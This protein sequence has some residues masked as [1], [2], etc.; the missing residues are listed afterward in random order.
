[1]KHI[2][3]LLG[4]GAGAGRAF[5]FIGS[6]DREFYTGFNGFF[7]VDGAGRGICFYC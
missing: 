2:F 4:D 7:L 6:W 3:I 1:M 5:D